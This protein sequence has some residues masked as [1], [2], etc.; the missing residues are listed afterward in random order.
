MS[1]DI[2]LM[3]LGILCYA[4]I[5]I[6]GIIQKTIHPVFSTWLFFSV[7]SLLSFSSNYMETGIEGISSNL[8]NIIDGCFVLITTALTYFYL[9]NQ[10][11]NHS[12]SQL[13]YYVLWL[14]V[15]WVLSFFFP[16]FTRQTKRILINNNSITH[17]SVQIILVL[18][19][20]PLWKQLRNATQHKESL[21][22][23]MLNRITALIGA[24]QPWLQDA[25]LP[26]I[27]TLRSAVCSFSVF[28]LLLLI[29]HRKRRSLVTH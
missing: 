11:F 10:H 12:E 20:I 9:K 23:R 2:L 7:A 1:I 6:Y 5:Y 28:V 25:P 13:L 27:L 14:W 4:S 16:P 21:S 24:R 22:M 19:Y 3:I 26:L 29:E 8:Y 18:A 17:I 15:F